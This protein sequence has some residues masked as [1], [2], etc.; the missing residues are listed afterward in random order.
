[1]AENEFVKGRS[2]ITKRK[3][4]LT[5]S[6]YVVGGIALLAGVIAVILAVTADKGQT[7]GEL[8]DHSGIPSDWQNRNILGSPDAPVTVQAWEDFRCP[9]CAAFNQRIKP[10]LVE[11]YIAGGKVKLEFHHFPLQ[12]HEP[13]ASL[14]AQAS[15]CAADQGLFWA[16]HDRVFQATSS[17]PSAFL[18]ERLIDYA[19]ELNLDEDT[20]TS[21]L[22]NQK[23][24]LTISESL[25][26][27]RTAGHNSTP[28]VLVDGER[29][30]N[31]LDYEAVSSAIDKQLSTD[32]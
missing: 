6:L 22:T 13:G 25:Q 31:P 19:V 20:F 10:G 18:M 12:Q 9:A 17:G 29:V 5:L 3:Q 15:E 27:A 26:L 21:C 2:Q 28:T 30:D 11:N 16:Y 7:A 8:P 14:A 23:H 1:M 4:R 24:L 32:Q